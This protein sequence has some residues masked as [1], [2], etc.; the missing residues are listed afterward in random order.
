M[1]SLRLSVHSTATGYVQG[2]H[3]VYSTDLLWFLAAAVV[4]LGCIL[5]TIPTYW[6]YWRIGRSV[7]FSPLEIAKAFEA[8]MM[9]DCNSNSTARSIAKGMGDLPVKYGCDTST[10]QV[11]SRLLFGSPGDVFRPQTNSRFMR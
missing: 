8:P 5:L 7:S 4:E 1:S 10:V 3:D 2:D 6:R 9:S 11:D